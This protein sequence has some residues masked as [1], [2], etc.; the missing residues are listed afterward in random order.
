MAPRP[1]QLKAKLKEIL[2]EVQ[3]IGRG[4]AWAHE[5]AFSPT[6]AGN[7]FERPMRRSGGGTSDSTLATVEDGRKDAARAAVAEAAKDVEEAR[8]RLKAARKKLDAATAGGR[9]GPDVGAT[10]RSDE[11]ARYA[12]AKRRRD[13]RGEGFGDG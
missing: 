11:L 4:Y 8:R 6:A 2:E 3:D 1:K 10:V 7:R 9:I 5:Y 13:G 12:D